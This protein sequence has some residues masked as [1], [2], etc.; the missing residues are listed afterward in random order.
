MNNG[1]DTAY[2]LSRGFRAVAIE[3]NP[4]L[5]EQAEK[6]FEPEIKAG[7][8]TL[9]HIGVTNSDGE[10]PTISEWSSFDEAIPARD[11]NPRHKMMVRCR[12]FRSIL[13]EFGTLGI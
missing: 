6:L 9:L 7:R 11:D 10:L 1:D 8:L 3:D 4:V 13:D 5:V 2:Y 12:R